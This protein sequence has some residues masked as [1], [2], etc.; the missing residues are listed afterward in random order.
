LFP[1]KEAAWRI[2]ALLLTGTTGMAAGGWLGGV[3]YDQF[4]SYAPA[5]ATGLAANILNLAILTGLVI[6]WRRSLAAIPATK[7]AAAG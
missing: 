1:A 5:F 4:G 7:N 2:P 6:A 3:I